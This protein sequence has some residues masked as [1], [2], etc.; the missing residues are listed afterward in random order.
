MLLRLTY[1]TVTNTFALLRLL[2]M[3]DRGKEIEILALRHQLLVL[4]LQVGRPEF[5]DTDRV[6]LAGLLHRLPT[7]RLRRLLLR[8]RERPVRIPQ[9]PRRTRRLGI[10]VAAT[11]TRPTDGQSTRVASPY[12]WCVTITRTAQSGQG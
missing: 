12:G 10:K 8:P 4:Q 11:L 3:R 9:N 7:G 2:P 5:T 6:V 1:L